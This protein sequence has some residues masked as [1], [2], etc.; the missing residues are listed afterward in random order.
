MQELLNI[1]DEL[2]YHGMVGLLKAK[3]D[4]LIT[5]DEYH[6]LKTYTHNHYGVPQD[7]YKVLVWSR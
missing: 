1:L 4:K 6:D 5:N 7:W 3:R 2:G